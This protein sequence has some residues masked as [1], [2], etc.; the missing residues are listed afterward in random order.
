MKNLLKFN[1]SETE[2]EEA[3]TNSSPNLSERHRNIKDYIQRTLKKAKEEVEYE[4]K[5]K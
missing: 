1:K 2:I 3:I 5:K 4:Q